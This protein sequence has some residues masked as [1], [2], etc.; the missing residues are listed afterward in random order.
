MTGWAQEGLWWHWP[1]C[2]SKGAASGFLFERTKGQMWQV[3]ATWWKGIHCSP[4]GRSCPHKHKRYSQG[5]VPAAP[6][7]TRAETEVL[8][9]QQLPACTINTKG[10]R[11][12]PQ[13]GSIFPTWFCALNCTLPKPHSLRDPKPAAG[14]AVGGY[15]QI[16]GCPFSSS[17][18][19][20][21]TT[22]RA[23]LGQALT[24]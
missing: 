3:W 13:Q 7:H 10:S 1:Q 18:G 17:C 2:S 15:S 21:L 14:A 19:G 8:P 22:S 12:I 5:R 6:G 4:Q 11:R 24:L 20:D 16:R 9:S 23:V